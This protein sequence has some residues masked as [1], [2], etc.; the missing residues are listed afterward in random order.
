M[1][2][3]LKDVLPANY[4]SVILAVAGG[5]IVNIYHITQVAAARKKFGVKA[6]AITSEDHPE[7]NQVMRAHA[8]YLENYPFFAVTTLL[9]GLQYP[10]VCAG[11]GFVFL[12]GRL[13]YARAYA[14]DPKKR[15]P[16]FMI[17]SLA[18]LVTLGAT[19]GYGYR[20]ARASGCSMRFWK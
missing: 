9:G 16:G 18:Q 19:I 17:S 7:F 13:I 3:A 11:A 14:Q 12:F 6:P 20:F 8:N 2:V 15:G 10:R 5:S 4:G 1:A